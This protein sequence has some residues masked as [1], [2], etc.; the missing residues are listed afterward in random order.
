M[1]WLQ[2]TQ[3]IAVLAL[4]ANVI[5]GLITVCC[6]HFSVTDSPFFVLGCEASGMVQLTNPARS[7][8]PSKHK[9]AAGQKFRLISAFL[10]KFCVGFLFCGCG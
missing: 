3:Q 7:A 9:P 4:G 5:N 8:A 10:E 6:H 1:L 2:F